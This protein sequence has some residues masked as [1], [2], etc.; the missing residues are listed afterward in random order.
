VALLHCVSSY[1]TPAASEKPAGDLHAAARLP[2]AIGLSDHGSG[3]VSAVASVVLG[4]CV[5]ERHL[6][7]ATTAT[8]FDRAVSSTPSEL[9]AIVEAM[10]HARTALG[11]GVK[12]CQ[13][14]E[15]VNVTASRRGLYATRTLRA[16][17]VIGPSDIIALRPATRLAPSNFEDLLA[18]WSPRNRGRRAVRAGRRRGAERRVTRTNVL[19]TAASRR[20][21]LVKGFKAALRTLGLQGS[22]IV[23]DVN[24][25]SPAVYA[26]DVP[27]PSDGDRAALPG[28]AAGDL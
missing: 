13:R 9:K 11:D 17:D 16:G 8:R 21:P 19:I 4:S 2:A 7:L 12:Q 24:P 26:A 18:R 15:A 28:R 10:E 27:T 1:P 6:V 14:A 23:T 5:Y 22:V 20:V 3:L 25:L